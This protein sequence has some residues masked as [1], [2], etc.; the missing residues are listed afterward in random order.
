MPCILSG[1]TDTLQILS[2][3]QHVENAYCYGIGAEICYEKMN[4]CIDERL[5]TEKNSKY[6]M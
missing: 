1:E 5:F 3:D 6:S 4:A 2:K